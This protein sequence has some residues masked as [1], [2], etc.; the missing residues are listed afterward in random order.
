MDLTTFLQQ[1]RPEW[2]ELEELLE[3]VEGSGL[4][5]LDDDQAVAFGRLYRRAASD[6]NQAQT[7]VR[8]ESTVRYLND[9]VARCYLV[10]YGR[11]RV[12]FWS[13]LVHFLWEYP[14]I[15]RRNLHH[16]LLATVVF[17]AGAAIGF[18]ASYFDPV[19][20]LF[21]LPAEMPTITPDDP[22]AHLQ[23]SG[24]L[25]AFS[26]F[27][28]TN[29]VRVSLLVFVLG[30]AFAVGTT[31]LLFYNGLVMGALGAVFVEA[32]ALLPF[33]TGILPHGV[34]E[35]PACLLGGAAGYVLAEALWRA[36]PWPRLQ[37][38]TRQS[39]EA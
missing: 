23:T 8:G 22:T 35:I 7:F 3:R 25:S 36:R 12:R 24:E 15:F 26:S 13:L 4:A 17:F 2:R 16:F 5:S 30:I 20:R 18:L 9:L 28:F 6:L 21:L 32:G 27:L 33:A 14:A 11:P 38:L 39:R 37:E 34:L 19:S 31:Y 1:R 10:I 29:N